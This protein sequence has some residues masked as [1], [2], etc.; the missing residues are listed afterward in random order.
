VARISY[1]GLETFPQYELARRQMSGPGGLISFEIDGGVEMGMAFMNRLQLI[2]RAVSLGDTETLIQ[3][4]ASMTHAIYGAEERA[5]HGISDGLLRLSVGLENVDDL[6][7]DL[8][9]ALAAV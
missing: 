9:R 7:D 3:H 5:R 1:P 2:H 4:P 6:C 8:E